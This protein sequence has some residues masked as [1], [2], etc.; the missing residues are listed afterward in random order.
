MVTD[1]PPA[2]VEY[3][4]VLSETDGSG[5][6]AAVVPKLSCEVRMPLWCITGFDG[7]I[8]L[9]DDGRFR[10]WRLTSRLQ[11]SAA[12]L[13]II[14]NK[15][16]ASTSDPAPQLIERRDIRDENLQSHVTVRYRLNSEPGCQLEFRWLLGGPDATAQ[17]RFMRFGILVCNAD[18]CPAQL[19]Q[20][21]VSQLEKSGQE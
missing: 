16:C 4:I 20:H 2:P 11:R 1:L 9:Q 10:T 12:P 13:Y 3:A 15:D 19:S 6:S 21:A 14:E 5:P 7:R 17:E 8:E 18:F